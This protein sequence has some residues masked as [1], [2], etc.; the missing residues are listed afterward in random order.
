MK[1]NQYAIMN[2]KGEY[3]KYSTAYKYETEFTDTLYDVHLWNI[4]E[5]AEKLAN[6]LETRGIKDL[7]VVLI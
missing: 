7:K 3:I 5:D 6:Y 4:K 1:Y 2:N